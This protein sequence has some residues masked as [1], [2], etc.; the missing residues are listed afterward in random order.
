MIYII[1]FILLSTSDLVTS[2]VKDTNVNSKFIRNICS[3]IS[4]TSDIGCCRVEKA[5]LFFGYT[6]LVLILAFIVVPTLFCICGFRSIG[7]RAESYAASYQA[8]HGTSKPFSCLQS[9]AMK[10]N[11]PWVIAVTGTSLAA[12]KVFYC[13]KK[14][15]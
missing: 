10:G 1:V 9:L 6:S 3:K 8:V 12:M 13:D 4:V 11:V 2:E 15:I 14:C 7:V 5:V